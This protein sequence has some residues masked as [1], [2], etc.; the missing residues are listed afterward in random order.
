M[1]EYWNFEMETMMPERIKVLQLQLLNQQLQR[2]RHAPAYRGK[3]PDKIHSL[4]EVKNLPLTCKD[5]LRVNYPYGFLALPR[6]QITRLNASSGTTGIPTLSF[7]SHAD[8]NYIVDRSCRFMYMA[9]IRPGTVVQ[10]M[11][12]SGLF[13]G[14]W[15]HNEG[16]LKIGGSLLPVGPG[17][18]VRQIQLLKQLS[19]EVCMTTSGYIQYLLSC[20]SPDDIQQ[21]K[22]QKALIGA[23]PLPINFYSVAKKQYHVEL[24]GSYGMTE[25]GGPIACDCSYRYGLHLFEDQFYCEIVDPDT[26]EAVPD[27]EYGELVIT[28]L[29]QEA[30]PLIRYRTRDITRFL[31]GSCPCGRQHK[32]IDFIIKRSDDMMIINGVNVYPSQIEECIYQSLPAATNWQIHVQEQDGLKKIRLDLELPDE[33]LHNPAYLDPLKQQMMSNL[34]ASITVSPVLN[35][36]P[37]GTLPEIQGKAKRVI[38]DPE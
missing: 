1:T 18:T 26:G 30:M 10:S 5:D 34:K 36:I 33:W 17:N 24:Y 7:F 13:V 2:A 12:G 4:D 19:A 28:P 15:F 37:R 27:G 32:R 9:G 6:E 3:L 31:L 35:F 29:Q 25:T 20:L 16:V 22:L 23:E 21:I 38:K 8:L 11:L 14:G